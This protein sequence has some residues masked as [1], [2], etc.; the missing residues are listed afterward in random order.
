MAKWE[1]MLKIVWLL[2][3]GKTMTAE[4]LSEELEMSVRTVYRYIDALCASGVPVIA[5]PGHDGGYS[6]PGSFKQAPLFFDPSELKAVLHAALF[7]QGAGYP[8][9]D[10]L[11]RALQKIQLYHGEKKPG[12]W[13]RLTT[14]MDVIPNAGHQ[15]LKP[16][17]QLLEKCV[18]ERL[19]ISVLYS[20]TADEK[21]EQRILDPYGLAF[22][23]NRWYIA[24]YCRRRQAVRTFRVDRI[25]Q[26]QATG[27]TFQLPDGFSAKSYFEQVA[28]VQAPA[29]EDACLILLEGSADS[30]DRLAGHWYLRNCIVDRGTRTLALRIDS[31]TML[32]YVPP[33]LLSYASTVRAVDPPELVKEMRNLVLELANHYSPE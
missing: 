21:P 19:T 18:A 16:A 8:F 20:K 26:A 15:A 4:Q 29:S 17:L 25:E 7:A 22:R 30:L 9:E 2:R 11:Q 13:E 32:K 27:Q 28:S 31:E 33:L 14:G 5:E 23:S 1:N 12:D 3:S 10:D 6:L 24:A